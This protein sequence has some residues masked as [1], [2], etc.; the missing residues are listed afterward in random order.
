MVTCDS[1]MYGRATMVRSTLIACSL[2]PLRNTRSPSVMFASQLMLML[3]L[4]GLVAAVSLR[5]VPFAMTVRVATGRAED[6][7][8][9]ET[10]RL[11]QPES[12]PGSA[13]H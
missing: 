7:L 3:D 6:T 5:P 9:E 8:P 2:F 10:P 13:V 12:M 11:S 1:S 4:L